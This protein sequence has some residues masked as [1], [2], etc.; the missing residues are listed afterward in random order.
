MLRRQNPAM[1]SCRR[2]GR[3]QGQEM[4]LNRLSNLMDTG[5]MDEPTP[6]ADCI[7]LDVWVAVDQFENDCL[8][9]SR[10]KFINYPRAMETDP[11]CRGTWGAAASLG[12]PSASHKGAD[13][14]N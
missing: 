9:K 7:T 14:C 13:T 6:R 12:S 5:V 10:R 3:P 2:K 11:V 8:P 4:A 1:S